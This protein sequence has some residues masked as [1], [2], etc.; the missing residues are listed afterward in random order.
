MHEWVKKLVALQDKDVRIV[1]LR[2][3]IDSAPFEKEKAT[4]MLAGAET[5]VQAIRGRIQEHEKALKTLEIEAES[6]EE[7]M[8]SFQS[9]TVMIKDNDEYRAALTQIQEYQ[10]QISS[11]ED[12]ELAVMEEIETA[13]SEQANRQKELKAAQA[14]VDEMLTDLDTRVTNSTAEVERVSTEREEVKKTLDADI[15][16]RY[17]RLMKAP[18]RGR[19]DRRVFVPV[20]DNV[21]DRCHMNVT[22]QVRNDAR[23]GMCVS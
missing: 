9:K 7:H 4:G 13:R 21:C 23:K 6:V 11:L 20:R 8:R 14:R 17:E 22:A 15:V 1:T 5:A 16:G 10:Q 19:S 12:K 3:Q 18:S 2:E